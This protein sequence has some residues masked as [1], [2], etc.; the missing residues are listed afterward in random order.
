MKTVR[1]PI[2]K[3]REDLANLLNLSKYQGQRT[4]VVRRN[5]DLA[6]IVPMSDYRLL[7]EYDIR[8]TK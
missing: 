2:S 4:I 5:I 7:Q 8:N 6:V 3:A 1:V